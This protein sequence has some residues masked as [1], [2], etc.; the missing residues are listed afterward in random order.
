MDDEC[1]HQLLHCHDLESV[2]LAESA[3]SDE[4]LLLLAK[5]MNGLRAINF[6]WCEERVTPA[7]LIP[8]FQHNLELRHVVLKCLELS[9][10]TIAQLAQHHTLEYGPLKQMKG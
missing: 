2:N 4:G 1:L 5:A 7:S 3:I 10:N 8:L 6:S 9:N